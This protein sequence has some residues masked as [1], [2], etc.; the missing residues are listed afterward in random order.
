MNTRIR[1]RIE[2]IV[3]EEVKERLIDEIRAMIETIIDEEIYEI[4]KSE[5][6]EIFE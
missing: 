5:V 4:V 1:N 6:D 3:E 2:S